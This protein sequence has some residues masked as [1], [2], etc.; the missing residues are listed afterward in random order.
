MNAASETSGD[1]AM[2]ESVPLE[3][4]AAVDY[5]TIL[6]LRPSATMSQVREAY[7]ALALRSHPDKTRRLAYDY[8]AV[9]N[10]Y[11]VLHNENM[12]RAYDE[13]NADKAASQARRNQVAADIALIKRQLRQTE[14]NMY[15]VLLASNDDMIAKE[16]ARLERIGANVLDIERQ[17][18]ERRIVVAKQ[19]E[20]VMQR[21]TATNRL[22]VRW[23]V[24][25]A[26]PDAI[27]PMELF[28]E[29]HEL[30][31]QPNGGYTESIIRGCLKKYGQ[32]VAMVMCKNRTGCAIVE[33]ASHKSAENA[34]ANEVC[35][36][37]NPLV[38]DWYRDVKQ[39]RAPTDLALRERVSPPD[40][41]VIRKKRALQSKVRAEIV[42]RYAM[43]AADSSSII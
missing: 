9:Q 26:G 27:A 5:Y 13:L 30:K 16:R 11:S 19:R 42:E 4:S 28:D 21:N 38:L 31:S 43:R 35:R 32:I 36:P 3:D 15:D 10:A 18:I 40:P 41:E 7:M 39:M 33:F 17:R 20:R 37:D 2:D 23:E 25:E 1:E 14:E 34:I 8:T 6:G 24:I 29:S 22:L 12:R